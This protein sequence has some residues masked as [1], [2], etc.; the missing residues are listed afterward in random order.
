MDIADHHLFSFWKPAG[1][2]PTQLSGVYGQWGGETSNLDP[3]NPEGG[4]AFDKDPSPEDIQFL[5]S[6]AVNLLPSCLPGRRCMDIDLDLLRDIEVDVFL[7]LGYRHTVR[8]ITD[9]VADIEEITGKPVI[10]ID[11]SQTGPDC[12]PG[13]EDRCYGKSMIDLIHQLEDLATALGVR[14]TAAVQQDKQDLCEA[15]QNFQRVSL[16]AQ[17]RGVRAMAA[18]FGTGIDGSTYYANPPDD[19]V[20]RMLEEL[21]MP[22]LH[23]DCDLQPDQDQCPLGFFWETL[24]NAA[25]F[26]NCQESTLQ[27]CQDNTP[28][29]PV[30]FWLY[31]DRQTLE[32][33][34]PSFGQDFPDKAIL[35]RQYAYWPI[36]GGALSYRHAAQILNIIAPSLDKAKRLHDGTQCIEGVDVSG[37]AHR[38]VGLDGGEFAC[39]DD[40]YHR[41]EYLQCPASND[42]LNSKISTG[43]IVGISV[44]GAAVAAL[45]LGMIL[46]RC[47]KSTTTSAGDNDLGKAVSE[48]PSYSEDDVPNNKTMS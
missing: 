33:L 31:D 23:V 34:R 24:R 32:V 26:G 40:S 25:F 27:A 41:Q 19:M 42:G 29:Y 12:T 14:P 28:K 46:Y 9:F 43:A 30:D 45:I 4:S 5:A 37:V 7:A 48:P 13:N 3:S 11:L 15:A 6:H 21:G 36:G 8:Y 35:A 22:L 10:Y 2:E 1:M 44:G 17:L 39:Y 47:C 20:L 18:Y 38:T 16:E